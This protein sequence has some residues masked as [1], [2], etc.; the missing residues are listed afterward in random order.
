MYD[1]PNMLELVAA[2]QQHL[3]NHVL[4]VAKAANYRLY[5]QTLVAVNVLRIIEREI[6][7]GETHAQAEWARLNMLLGG[8]PLPPTLHELQAALQTRNTALCAAIRAGQYDEHLA[9][10]EHLKAT[11]LEQLAVANPK[12]LSQ[13]QAEETG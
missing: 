11:T 7:L 1:R 9:L 12:Y 3:E 8:E 10:F 4:P 2:V 6:E 13:L 5:F